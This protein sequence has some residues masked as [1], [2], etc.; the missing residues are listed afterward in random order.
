MRRKR[1]RT[2]ERLDVKESEDHHL[3]RFEQCVE[4]DLKTR[5]GKHQFGA[6]NDNDRSS[7]TYDDVLCCHVLRSMH[8]IE[9][10]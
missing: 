9:R 3:E 1:D 7:K 4:S 8:Y 5:D 2:R 10:C 6:K